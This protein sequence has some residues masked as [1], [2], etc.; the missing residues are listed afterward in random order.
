MA[1]WGPR[2]QPVDETIAIPSDT[3]ST[4]I[5]RSCI[6]TRLYLSR[7]MRDSLRDDCIV[8]VAAL[9]SASSVLVDG[10][11]VL[12]RTCWV[13]TPVQGCLGIFMMTA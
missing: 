4:G 13:G 12:G 3:L 1:F 8:P 11:A 10:R 7:V 2:H 6:E 5:D 9:Q